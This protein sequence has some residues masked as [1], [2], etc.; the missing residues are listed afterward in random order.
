MHLY[1]ILDLGYTP[2]EKAAE[3]TAALLSG[4]ADL[5]Q[6]RAKNHDLATIQRVA[7][8]LIPLCRAAGVPFILND[9]PALA[10]D[11]GA[12]GVH[13]GQD[14]GTLAAAREIIGSGKMIGRSTHSLDQARAALA[15]GFDYIGFGPLF[16]TPTKAGRPAIGIDEVA[17]M[18]RD[19][20]SR[21]PAFCIGGIKRCNLPQVLAAGAHRVVIVSDL[22]TAPDIQAATAAAKV[23][24]NAE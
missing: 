11:L 1:A 7:E 3:T 10:A 20:G 21:I 12:D 6:L 15:E 23:R 19:V 17:A 22:L 5:L 2:E 24:L 14:D 13:I 9:H 8:I 4:G 16:P 18:Q